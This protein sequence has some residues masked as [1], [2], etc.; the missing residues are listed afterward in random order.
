MVEGLH[1]QGLEALPRLY[2]L[3]RTEA[4]ITE[5][6]L[7]RQGSMARASV[8]IQSLRTQMQNLRTRYESDVE[9]SLESNVSHQ[10][11]VSRKLREAEDVLLRTII[12]APIDGIVTQVRHQTVGA[13][14]QPGDPVLHLVPNKE[15]LVVEARIRPIDI[16]NV[17]ANQSAQVRSLA[18][19][20]RSTDPIDATI[21]TVSADLFI[22]PRNGEHYYLARLLLSQQSGERWE[23]TSQ[24]VRNQPRLT[25]G[26]PV[27]VTITTRPHSIIQY[28][29]TPLSSAFRRSFRES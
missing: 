16:E 12:F 25:A 17:S 7:G 3:Q 28:I 29:L 27:E 24:A 14:L 23:D 5:T 18:S 4:A 21:E 11:E 19:N 22:D 20:Y 13:V 9:A 15:S 26:M 6:M 10:I 1:K 8:Q 2:Y